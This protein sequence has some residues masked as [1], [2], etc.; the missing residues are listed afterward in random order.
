MVC[1]V[2]EFLEYTYLRL[3]LGELLNGLSGLV[4]CADTVASFMPP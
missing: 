1:L 2:P 4:D 3:A